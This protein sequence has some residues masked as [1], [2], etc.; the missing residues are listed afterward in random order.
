MQ[1]IR[2]MEILSVYNC[3]QMFGM[4]PMWLSWLSMVLAMPELWVSFPTGGTYENGC[5]HYCKLLWIRMSA[6]WLKFLSENVMIGVSETLV[7]EIVVKSCLY[8]LKTSASWVDNV[9]YRVFVHYGCCSFVWI[10]YADSQCGCSSL[11][12]LHPWSSYIMCQYIS[13]V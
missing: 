1:Y 6:K 10:K 5:T 13:T 4:G 11:L 3:W 9:L 8:G 2:E 12:P 7:C